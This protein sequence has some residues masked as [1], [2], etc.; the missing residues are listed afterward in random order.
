[1]KKYYLQKKI[2]EF[3]W[4]IMYLII[5]MVNSVTFLSESC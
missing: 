1:M 3:K 4:K 2:N 5:I